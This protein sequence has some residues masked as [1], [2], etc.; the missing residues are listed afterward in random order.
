MGGDGQFWFALVY[1]AV[2][3]FAVDA[4]ESYRVL[5]ATYGGEASDENDEDKQ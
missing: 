5:E 3:Y 4:H 1:G 2:I